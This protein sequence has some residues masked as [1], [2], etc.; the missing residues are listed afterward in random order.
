MAA[1]QYRSAANSPPPRA[2]A[3]RTARNAGVSSVVVLAMIERSLPLRPAGRRGYLEPV[4]TVAIGGVAG[5]F[6][7]G[8]L[9]RLA[10]AH[11]R[12][13]LGVSGARQLSEL[14]AVCSGGR[15]CVG[16]KLNGRRVLNAFDRDKMARLTAE[17]P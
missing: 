12:R 4:P 10:A 6:A 15:G 5:R 8:S 13:G 11:N 1:A 3:C 9:S 2:L 17:E 16:S 14:F 7:E